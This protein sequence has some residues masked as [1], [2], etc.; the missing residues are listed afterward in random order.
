[1]VREDVDTKQILRNI[2][3]H[4]HDSERKWDDHM[5]EHK[6]RDE[7]IDK[8]LGGFERA[9]E[10]GG[11]TMRELKKAIPVPLT[12]VDA[13]KKYFFQ[14]IGLLGALFGLYRTIA[15]IDYV[16]KQVDNHSHSAEAH[17]SI[18]KAMES[19]SK[20]QDSMQKDLWE[21]MG[22]TSSHKMEGP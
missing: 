20:G 8:T 14:T 4:I 15:T 21:L 10:T 19:F 7:R 12:L 3:K 13:F 16:N 1:M 6:V 22:K 9:L 11:I 5:Q 17:P 18:I 2:E